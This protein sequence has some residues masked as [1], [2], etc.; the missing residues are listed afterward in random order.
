[1]KMKNFLKKL[2]KNILV[3]ALVFMMTVATIPEMVF[4]DPVGD[5]EP[6][7]DVSLGTWTNKYTF[8]TPAPRTPQLTDTITAGKEL[9]KIQP[10]DCM[11]YL[12]ELSVQGTFPT[13]YTPKALNIVIVVDNS[14]SMYQTQN[15]ITINNVSRTRAWA[16]KMAVKSFIRTVAENSPQS[17][18][19]LVAFG[20]DASVKSG[21]SED[22]TAFLPVANHA[23]LTTGLDAKVDT[24]TQIS[25]PAQHTNAYSGLKLAEKLLTSINKQSDNDNLI[26]FLGDGIANYTVVHSGTTHSD[27]RNSYNNKTAITDTD[28]T[29]KL[30][31][32]STASVNNACATGTTNPT[33]HTC[34]TAAAILQAEAIKNSTA[35]QARNLK[36]Y[37]IGLF[38]TRPVAYTFPDGTATSS[39]NVTGDTE[40]ANAVGQDMLM[41]MATAQDYYMYTDGLT[42][43][44]VF[45]NLAEL[46]TG[47]VVITDTFDASKF[48][49]TLPTNPAVTG[50]SYTPPQAGSTTGTVVWSINANNDAIRQQLAATG[51][52]ASY[53]LKAKNKYIDSVYT[54]DGEKIVDETSKQDAIFGNVVLKVIDD[55]SNSTTQLI[56]DK[57]TKTGDD[58]AVHIPAFD[59]TI[60][61]PTDIAATAGDITLKA[62]PVWD[63]IG[64]C[65]DNVNGDGNAY[66][67][68]ETVRYQWYKVGAS[69]FATAIDKAIDDTYE[70]PEADRDATY[71]V[72][73][74]T[75]NG[76]HKASDTIFVP[77]V[78][79]VPGYDISITKDVDH[80]TVKAGASVMYTLTV[81]NT[82]AD[83]KETLY[84]V[85]VEDTFFY[86][87]LDCNVISSLNANKYTNP[88][89]VGE[90]DR[91]QLGT[92]EVD[93]VVTI[94]YWHKFADDEKVGEKE[95]VATVVGFKEESNIYEKDEDEKNYVDDEATATVRIIDFGIEIKKTV[96]N[97]ILDITGKDEVFANYT[98]TITNKGTEVLHDV[99][100][101]D[102]VFAA[103]TN[104]IG[105]QGKY[106]KGIDRFV[107]G[108]LSPDA[109][110]TI[111]YTWTF[112]KAGT[113]PNT[114]IVYGFENKGPSG[115]LRNPSENDPYQTAQDDESVKVVSYGLT[116]EKQVSASE[117]GPWS[118]NIELDITHAPATAYYKIVVKNTG[119]EDLYDVV[120]S[121]SIH[122]L[123][124]NVIVVLKAGESKEFKYSRRFTS[125]T[126]DGVTT[127][128]IAT[129][130]AKKS[131]NSEDPDLEATDFA[132]V[133]VIENEY[134]I[135]ILKSVSKP[136]IAINEEVTYTLTVTN[137]STATIYD[138]TISDT[139]FINGVNYSGAA[140]G[141]I[142]EGNDTINIG[143]MTA[144]ET[145]VITYK[146]S[147]FPQIGVKENIATVTAKESMSSNEPELGDDAKAT[148]TVIA[149]ALEKT[150]E[151]GIYEIG[152]P[153]PYTLTIT[154]P[155]EIALYN[156]TV[157]D[158]YFSRAENIEYKSG[159]GLPQTLILDSN[160]A[161]NFNIMDKDEVIVITYTVEFTPQD[162]LT[163]GLII[164][165]AT[166][167]GYSNGTE[168]GSPNY[169]EP[170]EVEADANANVSFDEYGVEITKEANMA[171]ANIDD[172]VIYTVE[173]KNTGTQP[174]Y[175]V[176]VRDDK[177]NDG[178]V[179]T[180]DG[181]T[182]QA[183]LA[184]NKL[185]IGV[186][187]EGKTA[188]ITYSVKYE[189]AGKKLNVAVVT[190]SKDELGK[191]ELTPDPVEK[192]VQVIDISIEKSASAQTVLLGEDGTATV[193]YTLTVYNPSAID[194]TD[195]TVSDTYFGNGAENITGGTILDGKVS[196]GTLPAGETA[197][198]T[199]TVTF[200]STGKKHNDATVTGKGTV[201]E[202]GKDPVTKD[203]GDN[204][205]ADVEVIDIQLTKKVTNGA[206]NTFIVGE[207]INYE[208]E[209]TN[210]SKVNLY[211]VV[212][213]DTFFGAYAIENLAVEGN[214]N[215]KIVEVDGKKVIELGTIAAG[216]SITITYTV[217]AQLNMGKNTAK[218][219]GN[220]NEDGKDINDDDGNTI[221]NKEVTDDAE[222][223]VT[224]NKPEEK[225]AITIV[226]K[227]NDKDEETIYVGQTVTYT[228]D[229]KNTG[230][231]VLENVR[232]DDD[233]FKYVDDSAIIGGI[234]RIGTE[235]GEKY[236][237]LT[238]TIGL[239]ETV[240]IKYTRTFNAAGPNN[241]NTAKV[242]ANAK[243]D[244]D[245]KV[246][247]EDT[248]K[249]DVE[250]RGGG[251]QVTTTTTAPTTQPTT[252]EPTDPVVTTTTTTETTTQPTTTQPTTETTTEPTTEEP[253]TEEPLEDADD[254][255]IPLG[256]GIF[257][258][259]GKYYIFDPETEEWIEVDENGIPLGDF[260]PEE[261]D[262]EALPQTGDKDY[263]F[264]IGL[265]FLSCAIGMIVIK[266]TEKKK[267][268]RN[269]A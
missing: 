140:N 149:I 184:G 229:I 190:S 202:E 31:S 92:L 80:A 59:V 14:A 259:D 74:V 137:K 49:I 111:T 90:T 136:I 154:N 72:E 42:I 51:L 47:A 75:H 182:V 22:Y 77:V 131:E 246:D 20:D 262:A 263:S 84:G 156:V 76:V 128:N 151:A 115:E 78:E 18:I 100:I 96:D 164:N 186:L 232:V 234:A 40:K 39:P 73:A 110:V 220:S 87:G 215:A 57:F 218:V 209:V 261:E 106:E 175:N 233:Y 108:T 205:D 97:A 223:T 252:P 257:E 50:L 54:A 10:D 268:R 53:T 214:P 112:D 9:L 170:A 64:H 235:N 37:T 189:E 200:D 134:A 83:A 95:N 237:I 239:G 241:I 81:E 130:T 153:V 162:E 210:T 230:N 7:T 207:K 264:Y 129:A 117:N 231:V 55:I 29:S 63:V 135:E 267:L 198:I 169:V 93:E 79:Y 13:T 265:A 138:V 256:D 158:T 45:T 36:L 187:S 212:L 65:H 113:Y 24:I 199:Y 16:A 195:V 46:T 105:T 133:T 70:V 30:T 120:V 196:I 127:R 163:D 121:D 43:N 172:T 32:L 28:V 23:V 226:K 240:Q 3:I 89:K 26:V 119:S 192:T 269:N 203:V 6:R 249:V 58:V 225:P 227:V 206:N 145:K 193:T 17:K 34:S 266:K 204:D 146:F 180:I 62:V 217:T 143:M 12:V 99:F 242:T 122:E 183:S 19:A 228:L 236:V 21:S 247:A 144:G 213:D 126:P 61:A 238:G 85:Y 253:T 155:N 166:V 185:S 161:A 44:D 219:V 176:V 251:E 15:N 103:A 124:D 188:V 98:L 216:D 139:F 82:S 221:P 250:T 179:V 2:P 109:T 174:L 208:L 142:S 25:N 258:K 8:E 67:K 222:A 48:D 71:L 211:K 167:K 152:D 88:M 11:K 173:V 141:T 33:I 4:A 125:G 243:D 150:R 1:M 177:F 91:L 104:I 147:T 224:V 178:V 201:Q 5:A 160:N 157:T 35:F 244:P 197:T 255:Y 123:T 66:N 165:H 181:Q 116:I 148:V 102:G 56:A 260:E 86:E 41:Y 27:L 101:V 132:D 159:S 68:D 191:E 254:G 52:T 168:P 69:G 118:D 171:V 114:A 94:T 245:N 194:L 248:A 38:N 60:D 107:I